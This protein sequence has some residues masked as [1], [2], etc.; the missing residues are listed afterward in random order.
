MPKS[1]FV[2]LV[3]LFF[4]TGSILFITSFFLNSSDNEIENVNSEI[5]FE[6]KN[7]SINLS[8]KDSNLNLKVKSSMVNSLKEERNLYVYKPEISLSGE[9]INLK[10]TSDNGKISYDKNII[11]IE[12]NIL[13]SGEANE[14]AIKGSSDPIFINLNQRNLSSEKLILFID[15]YKILLNEII[16]ENEE[17]V[18]KGNPIYLIDKEG[19]ETETSMIR[20]KSNGELFFPNKLKIK[21][22]N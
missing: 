17:M 7:I 4:L 11:Q 13:V 12:N 14:K 15:E 21:N 8:F 16:L 6:A 20:L 19:L 10:I 9:N 5:I 1:I 2:Y 22:L 18:L 3:A